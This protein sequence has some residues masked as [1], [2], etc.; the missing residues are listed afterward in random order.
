MLLYAI[1]IN[2]L[3]HNPEEVLSGVRIGC[4]KT[5][6]STVAYADDVTVFLRKPDEL[7]MLQELLTYYEEA[8]GAEINMEKSRVLAICRWKTS[9]NIMNISY[10]DEIRILGLKVTN[11]SN[12]SNK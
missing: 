3:Q 10:H 12:K 5:G 2:E 11:R 9:K 7:Q 1:C 4:G 8:T 6:T